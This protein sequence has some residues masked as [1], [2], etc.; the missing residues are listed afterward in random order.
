[1]VIAVGAASRGE[2]ARR[3]ADALAER[4]GQTATLFP[5]DHGGFMSDPPAFAAAIREVLAQ[6]R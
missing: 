4:L 3:S 6:S 2:M 5:G 1:L